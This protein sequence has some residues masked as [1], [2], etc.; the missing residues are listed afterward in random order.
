MT[1]FLPLSVGRASRRATL[2]PGIAIACG[3]VALSGCAGAMRR[4]ADALRP[5]ASLQKVRDDVAQ[6]MTATVTNTRRQVARTWSEMWHDWN[7]VDHD[8]FKEIRSAAG[9]RDPSTANSGDFAR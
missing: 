1:R 5:G 2:L 9:H 7:Y 8:S 4:S 6:D 3:L